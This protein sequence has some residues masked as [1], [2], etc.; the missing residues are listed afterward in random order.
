MPGTVDDVC[1]SADGATLFVQDGAQP[2]REFKDFNGIRT[3]SSRNNHSRSSSALDRHS[4]SSESL[5][6]HSSCS[7]NGGRQVFFCCITYL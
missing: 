1:V 7:A 5:D 4:E 3:W 6:N 2:S